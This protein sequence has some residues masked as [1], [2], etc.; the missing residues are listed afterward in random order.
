MAVGAGH[1]PLAD[2][3]QHANWYQPQRGRRADLLPRCYAHKNH[4]DSPRQ[5]R[6]QRKI[7]YRTAGW[8]T[9]TGQAGLPPPVA[10]G[11]LMAVGGLTLWFLA[12]NLSL[13]YGA[14]RLPANTTSVIMISEVF[15]ASASAVAL[16][17][18]T[19]GPREAVGAVMILGGAVLASVQR[20]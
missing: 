1:A 7:K 3:G 9:H 18:G 17:A 15:F 4:S 10:W 20:D 14:A 13:Q 19:L 12:S 5:G 8:L 2:R 11:W 6:A 16:G